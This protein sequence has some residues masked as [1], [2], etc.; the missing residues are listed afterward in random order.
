M[1]FRSGYPGLGG[2]TPTFTRGTVSGFLVDEVLGLDRGWIK[3]D[4]E[5]NRGNSGGMAINDRGELIGIPTLVF[6]DQEVSGK[7][8]EVRPIHHAQ[9]FLDQVPK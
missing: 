7:L 9:K 4:A 2:D 1:L 6:S 5:I 8:G 3:T